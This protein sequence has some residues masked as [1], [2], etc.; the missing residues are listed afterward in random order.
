MLI[1][2]IGGGILVTVS[3]VTQLVHRGGVFPDST[4]AASSIALQIGGQ[5]FGAVFHAGLAAAQFA[6]GLAAQ[7]SASR[8]M[9]AMGR[10]SV[11][12]TAVF[13][14]LRAKFHTPFLNLVI[15]GAVGL[16]ASCTSD[17][18]PPPDRRKEQP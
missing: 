2:L 10:D 6:C 3:Y 18:M 4:S 1:A 9:Y 8:L 14:K 7:A 5:L 17:Q 13:G 15:T 12:P 16:I 11:L